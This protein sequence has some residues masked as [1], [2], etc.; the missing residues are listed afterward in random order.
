MKRFLVL[1]M[2][3]F[4]LLTLSTPVLAEP[5]NFV[6]SPSTNKGPELVDGSNGS[7]DCDGYIVVTPYVDRD[8]LDED[9]KNEIENAYK[10]IV[11]S[12]D[13][14]DFNEDFKNLVNDKGISSDNLAVSDLFDVS[15]Y[16][17]EEHDDHADFNITLRSD[18]LDG[19]VALLKQV[20]GEWVLVEDAT[21]EGDLLKFTAKD[22][23]PFAIVVELDK[24]NPPQ[25]GDNFR[26]WIYI[27]LM[28]V[29]AGALAVV[30]YKLKKIEE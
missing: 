9:K 1:L 30:G 22:F 20:D 3:A 7:E 27:S 21:V 13:L 8:E 14:T 25:T 4:M 17:C 5:G 19:F 28:V 11:E 29:S 10:Q 6:V 2:T 18:K 26:W 16:G 12:D 23:S 15:Y 24:H